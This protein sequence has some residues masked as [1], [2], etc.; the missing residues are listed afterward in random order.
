[1]ACATDIYLPSSTFLIFEQAKVPLNSPS[2]LR[3]RSVQ[4][5][6]GFARGRKL[7]IAEPI[8]GFH[9]FLAPAC[10]ELPLFPARAGRG[11]QKLQTK[12]RSILNGWIKGCFDPTALLLGSKVQPIGNWVIVVL[13]VLMALV[14]IV[15]V[16]PDTT[17]VVGVTVDLT[18]LLDGTWTCGG[19]AARSY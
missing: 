9:S 13:E 17:I 5:S 4:A 8:E 19:S 14:M 7:F 18:S 3:L 16:P 11:L 2:A 1:M 6:S 12:T 10:R 15:E